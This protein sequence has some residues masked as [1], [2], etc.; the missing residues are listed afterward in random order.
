VLVIRWY[1]LGLDVV[2]PAYPGQPVPGGAALLGV[3]VATDQETFKVMGDLLVIWRD[4]LA[5]AEA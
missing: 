5:I 3:T 4:D 2:V 1:S